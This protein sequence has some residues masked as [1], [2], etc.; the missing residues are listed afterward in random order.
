M[1]LIF[2]KKEEKILCSFLNGNFFTSC[3]SS[4]NHKNGSIN[5][6]TK[7]YDTSVKKAR[8]IAK[9]NAKQIGRDASVV[10]RELE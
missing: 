8:S 9:R 3:C 2:Q 10:C 1:K 4:K 5:S 6:R 7:I